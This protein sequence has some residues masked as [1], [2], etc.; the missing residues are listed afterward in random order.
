MEKFDK[1]VF[2][3]F[4]RYNLPDG[5][6]LISGIFLLRAIWIRNYLISQVY[7]GTLIIFSLLFEILQYFN[8]TPGTFDAIDLIFM[9]IIA[10]VEQIIYFLFL[11]E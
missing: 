7:I 5:L 6:W 11:K 1:L 8:I 3:N 9:G 2:F 10:L 4:L